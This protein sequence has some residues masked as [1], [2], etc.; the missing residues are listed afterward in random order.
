MEN[1]TLDPRIG[2]LNNGRFYA[3]LDGY[4][5]EPFIGTLEDVKEA[6]GILGQYPQAGQ[7]QKGP[8]SK[9]YTVVV[10]F[11]RPAWFE[12]HGIEIRDIEA[13]SKSAAIAI[14]RVR[15]RH[16]GHTGP[17]KGRYWFT[18]VETD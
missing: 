9:R 6:L 11:Q 2:Q 1:N 14:A 18:A 8:N 12:I 16:D 15:A 3:Y 10:H 7:S 13:P 5:K 17:Q 4:E